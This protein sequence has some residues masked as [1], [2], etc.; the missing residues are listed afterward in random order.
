MVLHRQ[1]VRQ[2]GEFK[3][4]CQQRTSAGSSAAPSGAVRSGLARRAGHPG[5]GCGCGRTGALL[6]GFIAWPVR[7][8]GPMGLFHTALP[9]ERRQRGAAPTLVTLSSTTPCST[10]EGGQH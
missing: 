6:A 3:R 7:F 1:A 4:R 8:R 2:A 10:A 9:H 5:C